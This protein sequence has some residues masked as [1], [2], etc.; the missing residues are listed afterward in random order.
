MNNDEK[1]L[2]KIGNDMILTAPFLENDNNKSG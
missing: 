2:I 1:P